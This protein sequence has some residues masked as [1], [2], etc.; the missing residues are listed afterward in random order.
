M[1]TSISGDQFLNYV[2]M[3]AD[4]INRPDI[5]IPVPRDKFDK[6]ITD[7]Q[8][9]PREDVL[10]AYNRS[11]TNIKGF[12]NSGVPFNRLHIQAQ[13]TLTYTMITLYAS[14][15]VLVNVKI[16][17]EKINKT[18]NPENELDWEIY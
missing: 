8:A 7:L 12:L 6:I 11:L 9:K 16:P 4:A 10:A 5:R 17:L 18:L 14:R 13:M 1:Q 3:R 15:Y 2:V